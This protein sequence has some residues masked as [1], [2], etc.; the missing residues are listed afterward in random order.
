MFFIFKKV[1][2]ISLFFVVISNLYPE[3]S[4]ENTKQNAE[5]EIKDIISLTSGTISYA[6]NVCNEKPELCSLWEKNFYNFKKHTFKGAKI[7]YN[8]AKSILTKNEKKS[9]EFI[10]KKQK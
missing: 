1:F 8:F 3:N 7:T 10:S 6:S 5:T 9:S 2:W 4:L